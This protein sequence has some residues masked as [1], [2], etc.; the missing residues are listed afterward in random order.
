MRL[1]LPSIFLSAVVA[2]GSLTP[3]S[4]AQTNAPKLPATP[5]SVSVI[6]TGLSH[7]WA[8]QFL[9]DGRMLVTERRG[10]LRIVTKEGKI[11]SAVSG[12]PEVAAQGQGGLLDVALAPDFAESRVLFL[13]YSEPRGEG[14]NATAIARAKLVL[15]GEGGK[16]QDLKVIFQQQ[17]AIKSTYHFGSRIVFAKD[18][19]LFVTLGERNFARDQAQNPANTIGKVVHITADGAPVGSSPAA[20]GWDPKVW[21]IGHRN[22]QGATL[23]PVTGALWT[24]EHGARGGD[25]LN[26]PEK[27]KNYG[28][29]VITYGRDYSGAKIGEGTSKPGLEQPVYYW[30]PSIAASGLISYTGSLFPEWRGNLIVGSLKFGQVQRLVLKDGEVQGVEELQ[31]G[32]DQRVRDVRQGP[33]GAIYVVTDDDDGR[34]IRLAP[35]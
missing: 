20:E 9:P 22:M 32:I 11:S 17:P 14:T 2:G 3:A 27:G 28:W 10:R 25:E 18:G 16:L 26:H 1:S 31:A 12:V 19:T 13:S 4:G 24:V 34:I 8:L 23:D 21:S 29:P 33:D 35:K 6:A 7:A 30:D 15:E 5:L